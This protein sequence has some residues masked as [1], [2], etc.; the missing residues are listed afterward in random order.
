MDDSRAISPV[1]SITAV[2]PVA[3][4]NPNRKQEETADDNAEQKKP[5]QQPKKNDEGGIDCYA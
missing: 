5:D 2:T 4:R 3:P 1:G